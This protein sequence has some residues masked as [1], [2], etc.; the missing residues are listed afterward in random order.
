MCIVIED[1]KTLD[2]G[3][4]RC[5]DRLSGAGVALSLESDHGEG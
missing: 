5:A 4:K 3:A 1:F 2:A